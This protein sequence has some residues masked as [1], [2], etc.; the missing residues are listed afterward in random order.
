MVLSWWAVSHTDSIIDSLNSVGTSTSIL[1][2]SQLIPKE[3]QSPARGYTA[4]KGQTKGKNLSRMA[5]ASR[6][7]VVITVVSNT[8]LLPQGPS[9]ATK[10]RGT[11]SLEVLPRWVSGLAVWSWERVEWSFEHRVMI[12]IYFDIWN[13]KPPHIYTH[14]QIRF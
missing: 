2:K 5:L 3:V 1:H 6:P 9:Q 12:L 10:S 4:S 8:A 7:L 11:K 14:T 13:K